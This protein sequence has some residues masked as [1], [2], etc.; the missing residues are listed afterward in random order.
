MRLRFTT[1]A[2]DSPWIDSV[3]TCTSEHVTEM[4][5][6]AGPRWGLVFWNTDDVASAAITGPE[7]KTGT[8]PVPEGATS[9][10]SSLPLAHH[11]GHNPHRA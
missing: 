5:S 9:S 11:C 6:V 3:W 4:T 10:E 1:R 8:A 7:T 2:S